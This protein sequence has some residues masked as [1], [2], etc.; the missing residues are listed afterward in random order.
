MARVPGIIT[1]TCNC[2][3]N[4][5]WDRAA[6]DRILGHETICLFNDM[7][8]TDYF[9]EPV[10]WAVENGVTT[11]ISTTSFGLNNSCTEAQAVTFLYKNSVK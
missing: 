10:L 1:Y 11:G 9:Y 8:K 7:K 4:L 5:T 2:G 3:S 6:A